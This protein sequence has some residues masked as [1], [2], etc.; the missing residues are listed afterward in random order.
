MSCDWTDTDRRCRAVADRTDRT[1]GLTGITK[2]TSEAIQVQ[3]SQLQSEKNRDKF[4]LM[5]LKLIFKVHSPH[6]VGGLIIRTSVSEF[7]DFSPNF[8]WL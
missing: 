7:V 8:D 2:C 5:K 6:P 3:K 4:R 1:A